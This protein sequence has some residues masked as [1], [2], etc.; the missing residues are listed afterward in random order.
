MGNWERI[1]LLYSV[2]K[3]SFTYGGCGMWKIENV[4]NELGDLAKEISKHSI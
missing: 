4:L 3:F 1:F 2:R